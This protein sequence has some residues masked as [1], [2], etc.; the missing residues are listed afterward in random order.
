MASPPAAWII[1]AVSSMVSGLPYGDGLPRTLLPV[2]YT[3]APASPNARAIPRPAPRVAPATIAIRPFSCLVA[4]IGLRSPLKINEENTHVAQ[5]HSNLFVVGRAGHRCGGR[6]RAIAESLRGIDRY[7][8]CEEGC[9]FR[10]SRSEE[11]QFEYGRGGRRYRGQ[12][13]LF[14]KDGRD[15]DR[16]R[17]CGAG[18]SA[19]G[20]IVQTSN[21]SIPGWSGRRRRGASTAGA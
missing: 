7:R 1:S 10:C 17:E 11:T 13:R 16:Q 21:E 8:E 3:V 12:S 5:I 4:L 2:Q 19:L 14:R 15:A 6:A 9:G 18:Q 20:C